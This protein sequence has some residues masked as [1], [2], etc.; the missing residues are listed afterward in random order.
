MIEVIQPGMSRDDKSKIKSKKKSS[1]VGKSGMTFASELQNAVAFNFAD[2]ID[3]LLEDLSEQEKRFMDTQSEYEMGKY[4]A[5]I[6]KILKSILDEGV[7]VQSLKRPP[8][9]SGKAPMVIV[10]EIDEKLLAVS[11][12]VTRHNRAFNMM[13]T[14]EEIRGLILDLVQ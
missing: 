11:Q 1:S 8:S 12:A 9:K 10:R 2:N 7:K 14:I 5:L 6:K 13:K 4:K 3:E